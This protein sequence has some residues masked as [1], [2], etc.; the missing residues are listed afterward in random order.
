MDFSKLSFRFVLD[1]KN[2]EKILIHLKKDYSSEHELYF[3][4]ISIHNVVQDWGLTITQ[5]NILIYLIRFGFTKETKE[6]ICN[7]LKISKSS[8]STN[9]SY[10]RQGKVGNKK[11]KKLLETSQQNM[12][13]TLLKQELKDVKNL[14]DKG[15]NKI[16]VEFKD[17]TS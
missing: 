2:N 15:N 6:L 14:I 7:K 9:L 16:F 13:I 17:V 10:L 8:L 3:K 5:I 12:N 1:M 4:M 11:I